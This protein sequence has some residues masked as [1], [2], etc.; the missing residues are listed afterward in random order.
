MSD[1]KNIFSAVSENKLERFRALIAS[2][3]ALA[4]ARNEQQLSLV[5]WLLYHQKRDWLSEIKSLL[6]EL[7][8]FEVAAIGDVARIKSLVGDRPELINTVASDGF[9]AL[10]LASFFGQ[11]D[12]VT[13][14]IVAGADVD[15][16]A[17][18]SLLAALHGAV[19]GKCVASARHLLDAGANIDAK[20]HG[21]YT[22]LMAAAGSGLIEILELLLQ[23]NAD[24]A[25]TDDKGNTARD[26]ALRKG[27]SEA[28]ELLP[29]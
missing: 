9:Q 21:G 22:A 29:A 23:H 10:G 13:A 19:A 8:L 17:P 26:L 20:Q 5:M 14:L 1:D 27:Q 6:G 4:Q 28:A 18:G 3:P 12:V 2:D 25:I 24:P 7:D 15:Y 11:P 16:Q